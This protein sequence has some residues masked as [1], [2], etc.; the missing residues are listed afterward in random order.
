MRLVAAM[1]DAPPPSSTLNATHKH[2]GRRCADVNAAFMACKAGNARP[3][4]C[5]KAGEA[6]TSCVVELCVPAR[7][8]AGRSSPH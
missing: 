8:W 1:V 5:L 7:R 6:V 2:I 3:D 4:A